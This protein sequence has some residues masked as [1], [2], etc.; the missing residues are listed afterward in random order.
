[1][2]YKSDLP[3]DLPAMID[4]KN[5]TIKMKK[6]IFAIDAAPAAIPPKPN[7]AAMMATIKKMT[8]QR[9]IVEGFM[10]E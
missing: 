6:R 8:V 5:N 1:M 3:N 2:S 7:I 10:C 9:N 4:S